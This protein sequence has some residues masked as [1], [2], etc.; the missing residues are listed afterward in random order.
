MSGRKWCPNPHKKVFR[1]IEA[2]VSHL[3]RQTFVGVYPY[4]CRC[5]CVH[6][7]HPGGRLSRAA[8]F[9]WDKRI[10]TRRR[11]LRVKFAA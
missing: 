6:V 5:G 1:S 7:G 8:R 4:R 11:E 10:S 3:A 2:A 9:R